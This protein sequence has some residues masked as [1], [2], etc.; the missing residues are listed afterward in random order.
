M[1]KVENSKSKTPQNQIDLESSKEDFEEIDEKIKVKSPSGL[2]KLGET[3]C[4]GLNGSIY[5]HIGPDWGFNLC[6]LFII[7]SANLFFLLAMA[8]KVELNLQMVGFFIYFGCMI[9]Y[10]MTALK[11]PGIIMNPWEIELEE[12]KS[13]ANICK[14]CDVLMEKG[15]EHCYDCQLCIRGYDH[16]CPLS[17]KCIGAGNIVPFY[18]F[19]FFVIASF[20]YFGVWFFV[21]SVKTDSRMN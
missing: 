2:F 19:L 4:I 16:H 11:N 6:L 20:I 12:G 14:I 10:M 21:V 5:L 7:I 8:P 18:L 17:G 15:S 1:E 3:Y 13:K 9:T